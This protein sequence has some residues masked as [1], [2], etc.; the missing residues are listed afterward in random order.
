MMFALKWSE[1]A[2][3]DL[4]KATE[5]I[6]QYNP[7]AAVKFL[8]KVE[9]SVDSLADG[10]QWH[11]RSKYIEGCHEMLVRHYL[12]IYRVNE[13]DRQVEI[14]RI[15]HGAMDIPATVE[16]AGGNEPHK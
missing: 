14:V 4:D 13:A 3:S 15:I 8:R 2:E 11:R 7:W 1:V 16:D 12:V 6:A 10:L 5:Y 9:K